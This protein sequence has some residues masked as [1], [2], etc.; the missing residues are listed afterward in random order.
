[1]LRA[2]SNINRSIDQSINQP[3]VFLN[4]A[5]FG[6]TDPPPIFHTFGTAQTTLLSFVSKLMTIANTRIVR[7]VYCGVHNSPQRIFM[8]R[9]MN[10]V[11]TPN[12]SYLISIL[13]LYSHL[14]YIFHVLSSFQVSHLKFCNHL[15]LFIALLS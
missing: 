9:R 10:P 12:S 15:R 8:V 1:M 3:H 14:A 6:A 7:K 5:W 4:S 2:Y 13:I 11:H